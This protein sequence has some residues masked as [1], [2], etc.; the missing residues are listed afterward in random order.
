MFL[1]FS[2]HP[3]SLH[4]NYQCF[5]LQPSSS[6]HLRSQQPYPM[7][8]GVSTHHATVSYHT[9]FSFLQDAESAWD[10]LHLYLRIPC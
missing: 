5:L 1:M 9:S 7:L 10:S 8:T 6:P 3:V 4:S 2:L